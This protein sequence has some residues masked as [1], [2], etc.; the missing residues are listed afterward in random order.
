MD[1]TLR[2]FLE[3]FLGGAAW[4]NYLTDVIDV[5]VF[6]T[7]RWDE[8]L[9]VFLGRLEVRWR[10]ICRVHLNQVEDKSL[11]LSYMLLLQTDITSIHSEACLGVID[12]ARTGRPQVSIVL[13]LVVSHH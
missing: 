12:R 6:A 10:H 11:L 5:D 9:G 2:L 3:A 1:L 7:L 13:L 8:D 4:A